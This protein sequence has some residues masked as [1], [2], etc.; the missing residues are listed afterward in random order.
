MYFFVNAMVTVSAVIFLYSP[1]IKLAAVAIVNMEDAGDVASAAAM[2]ALVIVTSIGVRVL[3]EFVSRGI[4]RR[5]QAWRS[6]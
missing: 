3:Y 1:E 6:G 5:A 2:S 4:L